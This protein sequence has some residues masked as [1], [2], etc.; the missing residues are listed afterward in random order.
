MKKILF[1]FFVLLMASF[2]FSQ[3][4]TSDQKEI[5]KAEK[6]RKMEEQKAQLL[7]QRVVDLVNYFETNLKLDDKQKAIFMNAFSQYG[8]ELVKAEMK[9]LSSMPKEN[10]TSAQK[11]QAKKDEVQIRKRLN[12]SILRLAA[13]RDAMVIDCLKG[14]QVKKYKELINTVNPTSLKFAAKKK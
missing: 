9:M 8:F 6:I 4:N 14:R 13:K 3:A 7:K 10:I 1:G 11:A 5:D 2:S 12:E